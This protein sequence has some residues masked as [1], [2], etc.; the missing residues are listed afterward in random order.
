MTTREVAEKLVAYVKEGKDNLALEELYADDAVSLEAMEGPMARLEGK[1]AIRGKHQW[2]YD[3]HEFHGGDVQGPYVN[4][5]EFI[6]Q[7][8]MDVTE[9]ATGQRT[10][11]TEAGKFTVRDGKIVQDA[12]YY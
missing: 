1:D 4:G 8:S 2:W 5:D 3:N 6:V 12:F 9:K 7:F 11:M 10:Q